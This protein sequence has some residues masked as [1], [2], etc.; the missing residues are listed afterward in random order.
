[1]RAA[2]WKVAALAVV[3]AALAWV[4]GPTA[5]QPAPAAK[6]A[7]K[8]EYKTTSLRGGSLTNEALNKYGDDGWELVA[9]A[10]VPGRNETVY[11]FKRP[12]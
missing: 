7:A 9:V 2:Y 4:G 1:M 8:W 11:Y 5:A 10:A 12:K 6:A 3:L